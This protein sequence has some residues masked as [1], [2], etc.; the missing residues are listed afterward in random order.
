MAM[1]VEFVQVAP[2]TRA[3]IVMVNGPWPLAKFAG[4][5]I[6]LPITFTSTSARVKYHL[7]TRSGW[8]RPLIEPIVAAYFDRVVVKRLLGLKSYCENSFYY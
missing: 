1:L 5:W 7:N 2:P 4:T 6:F 8:L 3:A